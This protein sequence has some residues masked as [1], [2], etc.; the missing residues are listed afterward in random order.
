MDYFFAQQQ[1][2]SKCVKKII[3]KA[4][5]SPCTPTP[6]TLSGSKGHKQKTPCPPLLFLQRHGFRSALTSFVS[7]LPL[8]HEVCEDHH[9]LG[10]ASY[11]FSSLLVLNPHYLT[12][13]RR[14]TCSRSAV[15]DRWRKIWK[16]NKARF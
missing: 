2:I 16:L 4:G 6:P 12:E 10:F 15:A 9:P 8:H 5:N 7:P 1:W 11:F 14:I 3:N 13:L